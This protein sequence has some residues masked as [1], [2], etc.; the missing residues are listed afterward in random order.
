MQ[1]PGSRGFGCTQFSWKKK[2][3]QT[4]EVVS[5]MGKKKKTERRYDVKTLAPLTH[6]LLNNYGVKE[7]WMQNCDD[8]VAVWGQAVKERRSKRI[9]AINVEGSGYKWHVVAASD[10]RHMT[11]ICAVF[12][13][14][15]WAVLTTVTKHK[16]QN[17]CFITARSY[18]RYGKT[19]QLCNLNTVGFHSP[20]SVHVLRPDEASESVYNRNEQP[21][22]VTWSQ[23]DWPTGVNA[24]KMHGKHTEV[25][26][27]RQHLELIWVTSELI[28]FS[29]VYINMTLVTQRDRLQHIHRLPVKK[30]SCCWERSFKTLQNSFGNFIFSAFL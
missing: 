20:S 10:L 8:V 21:S 3:E 28:L 24:P 23:M 30:K 9:Y 26:L 19:P 16:E 4:K 15:A 7:V 17:Y 22:K 18:C 1:S 29:S 12:S 2:V 5:R 6:T 11:Y 27:L 14:Q 13:Q 25:R